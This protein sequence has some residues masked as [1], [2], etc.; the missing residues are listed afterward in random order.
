MIFLLLSCIMKLPF[1]SAFG[2]GKHISS[3]KVQGIVVPDRTLSTSD[4]S[5]HDE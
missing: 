1:H 2:D 5:Q 3:H 4:A